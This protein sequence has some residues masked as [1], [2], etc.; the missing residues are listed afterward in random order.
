[1][2]ESEI[3]T[4]ILIPAG[5]S[6][7]ENEHRL[8][9]SAD[10]PVCPE[11]YGRINQWSEQLKSL[12]VNILF[13]SMCGPSQETAKMI[14]GSLRIRHRKEKDLA[15]AN[16]GL[17]QGMFLEEIK[18]RHPKVYKQWIEQP[19]SVTPPEGERLVK[20]QERVNRGITTIIK[21]H[22]GQKVG[23]VLGQISL[24]LARISREEKS[25]SDIWKLVKEPLTWHEYLIK[26][27]GQQ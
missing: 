3:T 27:N 15:E 19:E 4:L 18:K 20:V 1:M 10:L 17:W 7:W 13:S 11:S 9:G 2:E 12:G 25:I 6:C 14:A 5:P 26:S 24:A 8:V 22:Q 16:L 21:K 23:V